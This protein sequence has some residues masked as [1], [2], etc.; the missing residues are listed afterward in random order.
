ME[1]NNEV[2]ELEFVIDNFRS[3]DAWTNV[4]PSVDRFDVQCCLQYLL[5]CKFDIGYPDTWKL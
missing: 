4:L 5:I 1:I 2:N 3:D